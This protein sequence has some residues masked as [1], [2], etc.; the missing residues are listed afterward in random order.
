MQTTMRNKVIA[1]VGVLTLGATLAFAAP[2]DGNQQFHHGRRHKGEFGAKFAEKLG[3]TD[4]QKQQVRDIRKS[5]FEAN[6]PLFEQ[7]RATRKEFREA[8]KANDTAKLDAL[9]PALDAQRAQFKEL[10]AAQ[11]QK[12]A[13][14]LTPQQRAQWDTLKAERAQRMQER[15]ERR[16]Q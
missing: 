14:V 3:L 15:K 13:L 16:N 9:K 7:A 5:F 10:R 11:E 4:A 6:K 2:Q 8:K 12:I 1:A